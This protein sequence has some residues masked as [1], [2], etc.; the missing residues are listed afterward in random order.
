MRS[1]KSAIC[2]LLM[3]IVALAT[4][5]QTY[6]RGALYHLRSVAFGT[7]AGTDAKLSAADAQDEGQHWNV[8]E[9][10]GSWRLICPFRNVALR[11]AGTKAESGEVNGSDEMQ[12]WK[13]EAV[14]GGL[15]LS[16]T[17]RPEV[18]LCAMQ[19]GT[20]G[21][22]GRT[23]A[24]K[25]RRALFALERAA[26]A[27][28]DDALTYHIQSVK[29]TDQVIGNGDDGGSGAHLRL[30]KADAANR[31]QYWNVK[32]Q[33]LETRIIGG[34]FYRQH[35]DDGGD[36]AAISYLLQWPAQ[37][38]RPGNAR[39]RLVPV[40]G[41]PGVYVI[42]S[43]GKPDKMW[44]PAEGELRARPL[45]T[46]DSE[47]WFTFKAV[48]KPKFAQNPWEDE[49]VFAVN[50]EPGVAYYM[51]YA[52][53]AEMMA[54]TEYY[55]TPWTEPKSSMVMSL[56][57]TWKFHFVDE[58]SKR[59]T[60][61]FRTD[62]DE[63]AWDDLPVPSNWEM[64][65]Y[66]KPIYCN[67]EYPH[68]NTPP[69]INSRPGFNDGGEN[70][71]I[72]PVGSYVRHFT[73][74]AAWE[75]R[76][77]FL[78]FNG[79]Y[80]AAMVWLNG[81]YVGYTQGA[82]NLH[83]FDLTKH[84][85]SGD[86]RLAVQ[87]FRW[88]DGSYLECQDMF[89]M[90]G[91]YRDVCLYSV[92][93]ESVRDHVLTADFNADFTQAR[94][95]VL[96]DIDDRDGLKQKKT[97]AVRLYDPEGRLV[98]GGERTYDPAEGRHISIAFDVPGVKLWSDE[99]PNLY[100]VH[101]VLQDATGKDE[102]A[103][104][105]KYG[106]RH[107]EIR[108]SLVYVN[109]KRMLFKGVNR[110]DTDPLRGRA[111]E[112][113][114]MLRDLTLMKQNNINMVRTSHYPNHANFY[115]MMDYFGVWACDEADLED[116]AN[117]S[118]SDMESWIPAFVDRITRLVT[119]DRNHPCV[120]FWSLGNEAG[121]GANFKACYDEARRLDAT[122][123]VHYEGTRIS[124]SYGGEAY[125]DFYSKMYPGIEWMEQN[126]SGLDKPMFVC[127]YAH[128]MGNAIGNL[129]EYW[130][131]IEQSN[132]C[133]GGCV[134]DWVDQAI[135]DPDEM[136]GNVYR[137][138]TGYDY[139]GPHQGNFCS[140]GII[141]ATREES[142]KLR[143]VKGAHQ[144]I[145][146][147]I[148][149]AASGKDTYNINIKNRYVF[150]NLE[151]Y[152]LQYEVLH[153][154]RVVEA[155]T[156]D[157]PDVAPGQDATL[158]LRL[159]RAAT[160]KARKK[161][162]EVLL[163]L[164]AVHK[165]ATPWCEAGHEQAC[166]QFTLCERGALPG[167]K[168]AKANF[169]AD[170]TFTAETASTTLR[171]SNGKAEIA[172]DATTGEM[173]SLKMDGCEV[174]GCGMPM[175]YTNH[176]WIEN[177]RFTNTGNGMD[178][179]AEISVEGLGEE[180]KAQA[181]PM[182]A[183]GNVKHQR[184]FIALYQAQPVAITATRTGSLCDTRITYTLH[185]EGSVDIDATF[186]PHTDG[187]RRAGLQVGLNR[188]L[189][190][191]DYYAYGPLENYN[192]R[193]DGTLIGR[194]STTPASS[195][196]RYIKPQSTGNREGLREVTFTDFEGRGLRIQAEGNVSFSATPYTESDLMEAQHTWELTPRPYTVLHLDA[197]YRGVGN[198]SCGGVDT[199]QAYRVE[200]RPYHY[201]LRLT[202]VK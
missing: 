89:R 4:S 186:T 83:E 106:F 21:L 30:E 189:Q 192:D 176:R 146:F 32:M 119:R 7:L 13:I 137:L 93:L 183:D 161:G 19:D 53:E 38:N 65:G 95:N 196:E 98:N 67:V 138:H 24:A 190:H 122:R 124:R 120:A 170:A 79:I 163:N 64:H 202:G 194:Y 134:W 10:S 130:D 113:G 174:L 148:Q 50:K 27:G 94:L 167:V 70:Y 52:N 35:I 2:L 1:I 9:L 188:E 45:D 109:G 112:N 101:T 78:R 132:S 73:L 17:N 125:S 58:P 144:W 151:A 61:F 69:Y 71:G 185:A 37:L 86:N 5:A 34:A 28:F 55:A 172:I 179:K 43:V 18:A 123:P 184:N 26:A 191:I 135:F 102:M 14:R 42:S 145:K 88:S 153:D 60:D 41:K 22:I 40:E 115:A 116:H 15:I 155:G 160:A 111:V 114:T 187:L 157:F 156:V 197:A 59:P 48:E 23:E 76:R 181:Q 199:R 121:A 162:T 133:I 25:E 150:S 128:A 178:G 87:V 77:T 63:S 90:S 171:Y 108:N 46:K 127:E 51:P 44:V 103:F 11:A 8:S 62:Y 117:Q 81:E 56:N 3:A 159:K 33:G 143:E 105:T 49:T 100:T 201:K 169:T 168:K 180:G 20:L 72:N 136:K 126:T 175:A 154:G 36:N 129:N 110:H 142:A 140:N 107:I 200:N 54:D 158:A 29:H 152:A 39:M 92:P 166:A 164:R 91:I 12:I 99:H 68:G 165:A 84:L 80:S 97:V 31:G 118:I 6:E 57:G 66:D 47:A 16:P 75:G 147:G 195:M 177:D 85:R 74:P 96:L 173:L 149:P 182:G 82:N 141:P 193:R 131:I 198:A 104:A 139:P